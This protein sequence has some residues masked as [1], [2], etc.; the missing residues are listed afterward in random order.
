MIINNFIISYFLNIVSGIGKIEGQNL[1]K[2]REIQIFM[3]TPKN[4]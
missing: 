4:I 3:S 1:S 2:I